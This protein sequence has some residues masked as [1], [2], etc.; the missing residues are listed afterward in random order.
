MCLVFGMNYMMRYLAVRKLNT[1]NQTQNT[2]V[3]VKKMAS[4]P[5]ISRFGLLRHAETLWNRQ[6]KIQGQRDSSLTDR[7]KSE[8][9]GWGR[10]LS[11]VSW[12]RIVGSDLGRAVETAA[13]INH[14][15]RIPFK[16]DLRLREQD[17]GQWTG[18]GVARIES[19]ELFKLDEAKRTG[20]QFCPPG[21]ED[22]F[23]VWRRSQSAL[24]DAA[25][26]WPGET[27]LIVTHEGVIKSLIYRLCNCGFLPGEAGLIEP[28]H[29]HWLTV[30][31]G[32]LNVHQLNALQLLR[33]NDK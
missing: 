25:E 30:S 1:K 33:Q 17:W 3:K 12:D 6:S 27:I 14:Y 23:S 4:D 31:Q 26:R 10:Q 7:G 21:G 22:R 29:L 32:E 18:E 28:R 15:L 24:L 20:W 11:R 16:T 8:A 2:P 19:E 5:A 13:I 9:D